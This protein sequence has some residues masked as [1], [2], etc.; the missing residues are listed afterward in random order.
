VDSNEESE[1]GFIGLNH[2]DD[3]NNNIADKDE[4]GSVRWLI[5]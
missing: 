3:N 5:A 1:G 2:D 4:S